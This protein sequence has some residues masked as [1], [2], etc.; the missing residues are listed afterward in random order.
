[1][2]K[3][4]FFKI[5]LPLM[6]LNLI[7]IG[8]AACA[9]KGIVQATDVP[10]T[11]VSPPPVENDET[12]TAVSANALTLDYPRLGMWWP[13]TQAQPLDDIARYD[14][15]ILGDW[16]T[17][18]IAPLKARNP[19]ILLLNATNACELGY[20]PD[21]DA[22][23]WANEVRDLPA[24]W[25]LTQ[26]G[27][28]LTQPVNDSETIFHVDA[29]TATDSV[30]IYPLFVVGDAVLIEGESVFIQAVDEDA[31]TLTVQ[32]GYARPASAHSAGT[33][34]AAH[35]SFWPGAWLLNLSTMSPTGTISDTIGPERWGDYN[36]RVGIGLLDNPGWDG[37]LID[38][39]DPDESHLIGNSTARTIDPD[40]SNTLLTDYSAFDASW[41]DG[42]RQYEQAIRDAI[43]PDRI[44]FAN[45]GMA[46]YDLLNGNNFEGFPGDD[47]TAYG[48]PWREMVFGPSRNGS[49]FA[50]MSH[51]QQPNLTM[52]ETYEDDGGADPT[53][54]GSYDNPCA[55]PHFVPNYRKMR[56]GLATALLNDGFYSYE[57]NTNGHG[58]LCL[59]WF[60]EYD[61]AG[62]GQGYL[63]QPLG[64]AYRV[65]DIALGAN[66][67]NGGDFESQSDLNQWDLWADDGYAA[68]VELDGNTAVSGASS[69][70]VNITQ[71]QGTD[72][73][74][75]FEFQ[76]INVISGTEYTLSFWAKADQNR[77]ISAWVQQMQDPW[78][79]YLY[80]GEALDLT[81]DWQ[82]Y[83]LSATASGSDALA[84][85]IVGLGQTTGSVWLDDVQLRQGSRE[86]WRRDYVG[87]AV[88]INATNTVKAID[89]GG[90][91]QKINGTQD[92]AVNDGSIIAQVDLPPHDGII[93]LRQLDEKNY[94]PAV[95]RP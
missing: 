15:V 19:D 78:G 67:L 49:Y 91:F 47:T 94:L 2:M 27:A 54:D 17:D 56:F 21:P 4:R 58:S 40:Q 80:F 75:S 16:E 31:K 62:Q 65:T 60:D 84:G 52:I 24:E 37:L 66:L 48:T 23:A 12:G 6:G 55:D 5:L 59:L 39:S 14:W 10:D 71:S 35:I 43:G 9:G 95:E 18:V 93:L 51:S 1:M 34:I 36:A 83:E 81:A 92:T 77:P 53:G 69:A 20:D 28:N 50:W 57:I 22:P 73:Q 88:L 8:L 87:G 72:W 13:D 82:Q 33:R 25:F 3:T 42:L 90:E 63:G 45:W 7:L 70:R 32:R 46:N 76:P 61:N 41:N 38:R 29:I 74:I 79:N 44:I 85:F 68:A 11:A 86:V 89:L 26:V 30:E 64:P